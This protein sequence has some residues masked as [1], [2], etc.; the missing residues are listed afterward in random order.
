MQEA[1]DT[2]GGEDPA[3]HRGGQG[4]GDHGQVHRGIEFTS[5]NLHKC[6][7]HNQ[8]CISKYMKFGSGSR[9]LAQFGSGSTTLATTIQYI[10]LE[11]GGFLGPLQQHVLSRDI[12]YCIMQENGWG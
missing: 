10:L 12:Q 11:R 3:D 2:G 9:I 1:G 4:Q 5:L 6:Y 7:R 8:C